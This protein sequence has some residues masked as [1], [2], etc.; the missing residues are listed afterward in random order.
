MKKILILIIILVF[1]IS[2]NGQQTIVGDVEIKGNLDATTITENGVSINGEVVNAIDIGGDHYVAT[3]GSDAAAGTFDAPWK[4][5]YKAWQTAVAGDTIYIRGGIYYITGNE[6]GGW[7]DNIDGTATNPIKI[8]AYPGETP[9]LDENGVTYNSN[10]N[11]CVYMHNCDYWYIKGLHVRGAPGTATYYGY[12]FYLRDGKNSTFEN[13]VA[14]GNEGPGI[15]CGWS[16]SD[17]NTLINCDSYDNYDIYQ[18]GENANGIEVNYCAAGTTHR[19]IGCRAWNNS[20]DGIEMWQSDGIIRAENCWSFNNGRGTAGDGDG[21]KLGSTNDM[22]S[23]VVR[24][25]NNCIVSTNRQNGLSQNSA[26]ATMEL[27]NNFVYGNL[28]EGAWLSQYDHA[29]IVRNNI[30]YDNG[31]DYEIA[32]NAQAIHDHND[33]DN[34]P[35]VTLT[36]A[37]FVSLDTMQLSRSRKPDGSLPDIQFGRLVQGSDLLTQGVIGLESNIVQSTI[38]PRISYAAADTT[39][40]IPSKAGDIYINTSTGKIYISKSALRGGWIILNF[41]LLISIYRRKK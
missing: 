5:W 22:G 41:I 13:L 12:G 35:S 3:W 19:I 24:Y 38:T 10:N 8:F 40:I 11:Y 32:L 14:Y 4:T 36:D 28:D 7:A 17:N 18:N 33:W 15:S 26:D 30:V 1:N 39:G 37:D 6:D 21:I 23:T 27:Y 31:G 9:I 2:L 29:T 34:I 20:D 16:D 25:L